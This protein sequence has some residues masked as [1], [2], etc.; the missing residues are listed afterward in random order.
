M[1]DIGEVKASN[2]QVQKGPSKETIWE[3]VESS[4][5]EIKG[6]KRIMAHVETEELWKMRRCL[7]GRMLS[8]C[9]TRSIELRL[10]AW[11]LREIKV[12][13]LG[14]KTFLISID[15]EDLF[16]MLEDLQWRDKE[17]LRD[18][19]DPESSSDPTEKMAPTS[20]DGEGSERR[21]VEKDGSFIESSF[22]NEYGE[23]PDIDKEAERGLRQMD[24]MGNGS[25]GT[26]PVDM[27]HQDFMNVDID[28]SNEYWEMEKEMTKQT[29]EKSWVGA[30]DMGQGV[31]KVNLKED[32]LSSDILTNRAIDDLDCM[33]F[34]QKPIDKSGF[35]KSVWAK[36][37][38]NK[39][40]AHISG[41]EKTDPSH[42]SNCEIFSEEE[43][44][45]SFFPELVIKKK[46]AKKYGSLLDLQDKA[47]STTDR[48]KRDQALKKFKS[49]GNDLDYYEL[50]GR[51]LSD[52]DLA[53]KWVSA[54]KEAKKTLKLEKKL[55][56]QVVGDEQDVVKELISLENKGLGAA[57]KVLALHRLLRSQKVEMALIQETKKSSMNESDIQKLWYILLKGIWLKTNVRAAVIFVYA[58]NTILT[59]L[60]IEANEA[61]A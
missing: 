16:L 6:R 1:K 4:K 29:L 20:S 46:K 8:V 30:D 31:L 26:P 52:S 57:A 58:P 15:D 12:H 56:V 37:L 40:N 49:R 47:L 50:S 21:S 9:S 33:G 39:V 43:S 32:G 59:Q 22:G 51:S 19:S 10:Q 25:K 45:R 28:I 27:D 35:G 3:R 44:G 48:R 38:D 41:N 60:G 13:R 5:N 55:G 42:L 54:T 18:D 11:G 34:G 36:K 23:M 14:G 17:Q 7:V 53:A 2:K 24:L 61:G